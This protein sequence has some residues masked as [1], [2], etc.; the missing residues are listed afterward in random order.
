MLATQKGRS[1]PSRISWRRW[2]RGMG[3]DDS[4]GGREEGAYFA[5]EVTQRGERRGIRRTAK[6]ADP[7]VVVFRGLGWGG[8]R[9]ESGGN[10]AALHIGG[11]MRFGAIVIAAFSV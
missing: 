4:R 11:A 8:L 3:G 9:C 5:A 10:P 2:E 7:L 6:G 1:K